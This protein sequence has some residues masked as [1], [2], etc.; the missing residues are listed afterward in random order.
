MATD[1]ANRHLI[2]RQSA[3]LIGADDGRAAERLDGGQTAYDSVL[4]GHATCTQCQTRGDYGGQTLGNSSD[5]ES[6]GNL[7]VVDSTLHNIIVNYTH[8]LTA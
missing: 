5:S 2:G 4:L 7:E 1:P 8:A 3:S 6:D